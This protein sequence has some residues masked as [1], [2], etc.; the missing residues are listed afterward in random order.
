MGFEDSRMHKRESIGVVRLSFRLSDVVGF[1]HVFASA[2]GNYETF[3]L[4]GQ[5]SQL[6]W[7]KANNWD[8][9]VK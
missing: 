2:E 3:P 1:I 9:N 4:P 7:I 5:S 6:D 8:G